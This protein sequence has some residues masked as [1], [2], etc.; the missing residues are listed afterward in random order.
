MSIDWITVSAQ[1]ANFLVL[2]L[3]LTLRLARPILDGI[4]AREAEIAER[5]GEAAAIQAQADAKAADYEAQIAD[6][7]AS[8]A[9]MLDKA[10][11]AAEA[12]RDALLAQ[13]RQTLQNEQAE[14]ETRRADEARQHTAGLHL[15]GANALLSLTRKALADLADETLEQR[16]ALHAVTRL[17]GMAG[18]LREAA[19]DTHEAVA[20]T[21]DPLPDDVQTRLRDDLAAILPDMALRFD[22]DAALSP[23]LSLRLGGAQVGRTLDSYLNGLDVQLQ[24]QAGR[25]AQRG[26]SDGI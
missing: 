16:I 11:L 15:N 1:I 12:E 23:G 25:P 13:A 10:R 20:L 5:M 3:S 17:K 4:D 26:L 24:T 14:R 22:T 8:R 2:V 6:L 9:E 7:S 18:D 19:G 21:R